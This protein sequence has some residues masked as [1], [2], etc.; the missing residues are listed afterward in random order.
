MP[1]AVIAF[2]VMLLLIAFSMRAYI[3]SI[4]TEAETGQNQSNQANP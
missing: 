2:I 3:N 4:P 1:G